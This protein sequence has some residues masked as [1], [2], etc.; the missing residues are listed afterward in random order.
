MVG[1]FFQ[2]P[3]IANELYGDPG[4]HCFRATWFNTFFKHK[5]NLSIV[6]RQNSPDLIDCVNDLE[7][8]DLSANSVAFLNSLNRPIQNQKDS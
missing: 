2:L 1:D 6:H 7:K 8:G 5:R 4:Y 3:P